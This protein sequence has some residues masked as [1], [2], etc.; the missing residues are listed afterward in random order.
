MSKFLVIQ[1]TLQNGHYAHIFSNPNILSYRVFK[2]CAR[3]AN[4]FGRNTEH[5]HDRPEALIK[6]RCC[7]TCGQ[8]GPITQL[9][10]CTYH[11]NTHPLTAPE[12]NHNFQA[13]L[14]TFARDTRTPL[15]FTTAYRGN[16]FI[17]DACGVQHTAQQYVVNPVG[18]TPT[19]VNRKFK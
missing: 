12:I 5:K 9:R 18:L 4:V 8:L 7:L 13:I 10:A 2:F 15:A 11:Y 6:I 16:I 14:G 17:P 3:C 19:S 1:N